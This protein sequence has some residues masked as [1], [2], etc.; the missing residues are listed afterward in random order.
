MERWELIVFVVLVIVAAGGGTLLVMLAVE[1]LPKVR[2]GSSV[3]ETAH[4]HDAAQ[5]RRSPIDRRAA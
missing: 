2:N 5:A 3:D 4:Q 1:T